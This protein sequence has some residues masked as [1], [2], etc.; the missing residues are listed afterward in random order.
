MSWVSG[1]LGS[2][3]GFRVW[4]GFDSGCSFL[5]VRLNRLC[6][7]R[8][9]LSRSASVSEWV[10]SKPLAGFRGVRGG[11]WFSGVGWFR[12]GLLLRRGPAQP[13]CGGGSWLS[14]SASVSE[15]VVSKPLAGFRG[16]GVR[17][18][19]PGVG[20]FRLGLLLCRGPAQPALSSPKLVEPTC[21]LCELVVSKPRRPQSNPAKKL[22]NCY[23]KRLLFVGEVG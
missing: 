13:A 16:V 21:S 15:R 17:F 10:V 12:L 6:P 23:R 14:R 5:A 7:P 9:W 8:S 22:S 3:S 20:W 18:W 4:G 1:V 11:F 2:G 19:L